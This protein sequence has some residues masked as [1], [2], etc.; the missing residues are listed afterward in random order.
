MQ[1]RV[2]NDLWALPGGRWTSARPSSR[3][4]IR[5]VREETGLDVEVD[6][7]VGIYS[8]PRHIIEY[9]DGESPPAVQHLLPR[10]PRWGSTTRKQGVHRG[11][12]DSARRTRAARDPS[13]Y[14]AKAGALPPASRDAP[15]RL[16]NRTTRCGLRSLCPLQ[17]KCRGSAEW[18]SRPSSPSNR[19]VASAA[20]ADPSG[21]ARGDA[22]Q[23]PAG[24]SWVAAC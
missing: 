14:S 7:I 10:E 13:D 4:P 12:V 23:S 18:A 3:P 17:P 5:E 6:G 21:P 9:S 16:T 15:S 1:R 22:D 20:A 8:D 19:R 24:P 2:D 11:A